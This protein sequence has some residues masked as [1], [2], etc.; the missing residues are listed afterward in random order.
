LNTKTLAAIVVFAALAI[1]LNLSPI[2]IPAPYAPYLIY[3]TWEIPIVTAFLLFGAAVGVLI[4]V[5]NTLALFAFFP[6]ALPTG[7]MYNLAAVLSMLL[8]IGLTSIVLKKRFAT[9]ETVVAALYTT[10][11]VI[12]R[13]AFMDLVNYSLLRFPPPVG[14]GFDEAAVLASLPLVTIFN[15]T[16]ALYTIPIGYSVARMLRSSLK[17]SSLNLNQ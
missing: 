8:G 15:L 7:P 3:Q 6:G 14:Y 16:L 12:F 1:A 5:V 4:A 2:K 11:G 13:T 10:S 17:K 9:H